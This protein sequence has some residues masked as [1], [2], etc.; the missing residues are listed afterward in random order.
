[1]PMVS[2]A[3]AIIYESIH[4][5]ALNGTVGT[6][7]LLALLR[8]CRIL[9]SAI[10]RSIQIHSKYAYRHRSRHE[11]REERRREVEGSDATNSELE[12]IDLV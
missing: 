6:W 8:G 7:Q 11:E 12:L 5:G 3:T 10:Y 1:M 2:P 4:S 9:L